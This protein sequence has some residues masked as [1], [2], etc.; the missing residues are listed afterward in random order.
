MEN[1]N[2][3]ENGAVEKADLREKISFFQEALQNLQ[4]IWRLFK[5]PE[6]PV[7][8]KIIPVGALFYLIMP[9]DFLPDAFLGIGQL[10]DLGVLL[11]GFK[12]FVEMSPKDVVA[13]HRTELQAELG[14]SDKEVASSIIIDQD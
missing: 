13:R 3:K 7:A 10:D 12:A 2:S 11:L 1:N 14:V 6:V 5:D 9:I 8:V 4:L